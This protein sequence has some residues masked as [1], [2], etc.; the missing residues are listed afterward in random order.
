MPNPSQPTGNSRRARGPAPRLVRLVTVCVVLIAVPVGLYLFLYQRSRVEA[1]TIRNFRALDAAADRVGQVLLRL[2]NVVDGSSFGISPTMLDDV[3]ER[4]SGSSA[5][6]D[7]DPGVGRL[8]WSSPERSHDLLNSRRTTP[9]Q[10]L[11]FRNWLAAHT[12]FESKRAEP[13]TIALWNQLHCLIDT[14]RR[15]SRPGETV[16]AAV[17]PLPR[18]ALLPWDPACAN[19]LASTKCIRRRE[20]LEAEPCEESEPTPRLTV[21]A[22]GMAATLLDCRRLEE[23]HPQLHK[24]LESFHGGDAV[25]RAIDLFGIRSSADL[26]ELMR[27]ATGYLSRFFD[28]HLIADADGL[29]LFEDEAASTSDTEVDESQVETPGFA[30]YVD[31]SELLRARSPG[32]DGPGAADAGD[33]ANRR[34]SVSAPSFRGRSFMRIV[35]DEDV[36][37]RVF[38]HPFILDGV[39][40]SGISQGDL[41]ADPA[42]STAARPARP[43]FYLVGIVDDREFRSAAIRMRLGRVT[44]ATLLLLVILTLT[45]LLWFWTAG[46]RVV[47]GRLALFGVCALPLA[48]VVLFTVLAC[49]AVTKRMDEHVLDGA[50]EHVSSRIAT[51]FDRELSG[52]IR[53]LRLAVPRLLARAGREESPPRRGTKTSLTAIDRSDG[54]ILTKLERALYCDDTDRNLEYDPAR[55]EAWSAVLL[56]ADGKQRVCLSEPRRGLPARTPPLDLRFRAYFT[57]PKEGVLWRSRWSSQSQPVGCRVGVA[58]DEESLIPCLVDGLPEP[59]KRLFAVVGARAGTEAPYFLERIDSVVGGQVATILAVDTGRTA[60]PVAVAGVSLNALDRVVPPRHIDFAVVDRETGRTLFHSDD[61]LAMTTNFVEDAGRDPALRSLLRSGARDTIDLVYTGVPVRAHVRPLRPGMPWALAVYRG[62]E[63][64]DRLAGL[65]AALSIFYTFLCLVLIAL[66]AGLVLLV[67]HWCKPE[68]L[69]SIPVTLGRVIAA[70]SRLRW[71]AVAGVLFLV[72]GWWFSRYAWPLEGGWRVSPLFAIWSVLA[73][74]ALVAF[75]AVG[76]RAAT[77][78]DGGGDGTC[79]LDGSL[80]MAL[81]L[82]VLITAVAI[83]PSVL[84]FGHHRAALGVALDHYLVDATLDSVDRAREDYRLEMLRRHGTGAAPIGDRTRRRWRVESDAEPSWVHRTLRPIVASS[85]LANQLMTHRAVPPRRAGGVPSLHDVFARTF[86]YDIDRPR[87][88]L[89]SP[90]FGRFLEAALGLLFFAALIAAHAYTVCAACTV[91]GSRRRGL[92]RLPN[93]QDLRGPGETPGGTPLRAIVVHRSQRGRDDFLAKLGLSP[94]D[95]RVE[96]RDRCVG[97]RPL[98]GL[99]VV[100]WEP[101]VPP[102]PGESLYVFDDLREVL[103]HDVRGRALLDELEGR[104][105]DGSHV[106]IWSRV[107]PD[108]RYSDRF[109]PSDRWFDHGHGDDADRRDRWGRLAREFRACVLDSSAEPD[110]CID[111]SPGRAATP[112]EQE[113]RKSAASYFNCL[114]AESTHEERLALYALARGGVVDSRRTA[115]LSSLVNRGLVQ[116]NADTGVLALRS[117]AFREFVKHDIDHHEL[118]AWCKAGAAGGWRFIWPPLVI[119]GALGLAFLAMANPEMRATLLATLL[120]LLP[121][122]LPLL[123]TGGATGGSA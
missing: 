22:G 36:D 54:R 110:G 45:P 123:R 118:D 46:D 59:S 50:M 57:Q 60:T 52:E 77:T 90:D 31:I 8:H 3:S 119:G 72:C 116:E 82:A 111:G 26:N 18:T 109:E 89:S 63:L 121:A 5:A 80:R 33:G 10:R 2:S 85:A 1:A 71:P 81:G 68:T 122:A 96:R 76:G 88:P 74:A 94:R 17:T 39:S 100:E 55:P 73:V 114:W 86:G 107:V 47:V 66:L 113:C 95:H 56:G 25:I 30:R 23:R 20:L 83:A 112:A 115:A 65:T 99:H 53:R 48:G 102:A 14:H 51:L 79:R 101:K 9:A 97:K 106:L 6:C 58:Q 7:S 28:S 41:Q 35:D 103:D 43:T 87:W 69:A 49:G 37:L 84:W 42:S 19:G 64:E 11:E 98:G 93:A 61:E 70:G 16:G 108:Y 29:I 15:F 62:H 104:V 120:G 12:L 92:V 38:V 117:E 105:N 34:T 32:P 91:V 44:D 78:G 40:V 75:C 27:E 24:A 67:T 13:G 21:G 4:L